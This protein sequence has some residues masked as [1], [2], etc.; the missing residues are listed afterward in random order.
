[1]NAPIKLAASLLVT[2][3][4]AACNAGNS[5]GVPR[6]AGQTVGQS[7]SSDLEAT[8]Y[9]RVCADARPNH[10]NCN[11]LLETRVAPAL[12]G[13][14]PADFQKA[15]NLPSKTRGAGKV[16]A[17]VDAYDNPHVAS[18]LAV[19]RQRFGLGAAKFDKFNQLGEKEHYPPHCP[20]GSQF[21]W[22]LE[23]DLDVD[24]VSA[25][26]PKCTIWLF[27]ANTNNNRDLYAAVAKAAKM[28]A[29]IIS[30][31]YSG[32]SGSAS[33]GAFAR[34]GVTYLASAGDFGYGMEDPAD[35][36][37]VVAVGGTELTKVGARYS[38][39]IW[40]HTGAGC[41]F[42]TKPQWQHDPMCAERTGN[43]V[44]AV[45]D[46]V[47]EYDTYGYGGWIVVGGTS[48][49]SP[50]LGGVYGLA[51]NAGS[52]QSGKAFWTLL[53]ARRTGLHVITA[54]DVLY[55]PPSL[56]GTYLCAAG[57]EQFKTYSGPGG[58]GTPNGIG[59]F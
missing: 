33:Y 4:V 11:V 43:D 16:V 17:I 40:P 18:D 14:G 8:G 34:S 56:R 35:Y 3:A 55:C 31:S 10:M 12:A 53:K 5:F 44:S 42:V 41:S 15:Y 59:A 58:W 7:P 52:R 30:N 57:T 48:I 2:L 26:C 49:G 13:L 32:G 50:L 24:M 19:Y 45:A 9:K 39:R 29:H 37:T 1:M 25:S 27:E 46:N 21:G 47:A 38:E 23:I 54:G 22:C 20:G 28:G 36:D 51:G 6:E